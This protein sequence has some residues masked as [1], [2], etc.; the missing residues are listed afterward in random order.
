MGAAEVARFQTAAERLGALTWV[1]T[2]GALKESVLRLL[3]PGQAV[4]AS[5]DVLA[6]VPGLQLSQRTATAEAEVAVSLAHFGIAHTGTAVV[7]E[8]RQDDRI[9]TLLCELHVV[10]LSADRVVADL[11]SSALLLRKL[12]DSGRHYVTYVSGPSRTSDIERVLT[13]G[14]HGPRRLAV[15]LVEDWPA[16]AH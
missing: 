14:V 4:S 5:E 10:L 11:P 9:S 16:D 15:L 1:T 12:I 13:I 8:R 7:A 2:Q 6:A 3:R